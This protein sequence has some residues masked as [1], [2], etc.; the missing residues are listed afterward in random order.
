[1][2]AAL[3]DSQVIAFISEV[4]V[5]L[6]V[7]SI[8]QIGALQNFIDLS[9]ETWSSGNSDPSN[10]QVLA[11]DSANLFSLSNKSLTLEFRRPLSTTSSKPSLGRMSANTTSSPKSHGINDSMPSNNSPSASRS[12]SLEPQLC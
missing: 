4:V 2:P 11:N 3:V 9:K 1:M 5:T 12:H 6:R 10:D 8:N 7:E